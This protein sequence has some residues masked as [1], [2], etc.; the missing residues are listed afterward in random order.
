MNLPSRPAGRL[1]LK[2]L[3][4]V[5]GAAATVYAVLL[6]VF[7]DGSPLA[8][9][10]A[11]VSL[12]GVQAIALCLLNYLL[13][14]LRWRL[15]MAHY[16]RPLEIAEALRLYLAGYT[17]T[18]TPGNVGE[19]ARGLLLARNPL[20]AT[21]SLAIFGAERLADLLS[22][23]LLCLPVA[24][25]LAG[26]GGSQLVAGLAVL[27]AVIVFA[28]L[29]RFRQPLLLRF[30]WLREAWACLATRPLLW[31]VLSL[32]AWAAQGVAV[33]LLCRQAGL[34][35]TV[36][37]ATGFYALAM[38]GGA[39]SLL[40]AGLGGMEAILTALLVAHGASAGLAL[41]I[42]VQVRLVTLWLAVAIGAL[43]LVYSAAI[44]RDI[45]FR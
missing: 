44:Q 32:V 42:T 34:S 18:P 12:A 13:R 26:L 31:L 8:T 28:L 3:L 5:M 29:L 16:G 20:S 43:A 40:P 4:L 35:L 33:W 1:P 17:F 10:Q 24:W 39:L 9:L 27:V 2:P 41:G 36:L 38:V 7:A 45:S 37:E 19:A 15:W 14:G 30:A 22:L 6:A 21:Q 23:L 25:W 11:L